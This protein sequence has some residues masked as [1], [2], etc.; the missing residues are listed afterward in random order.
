ML[1]TGDFKVVN[2]YTIVGTFIRKAWYKRMQEWY[3]VNTV[4]TLSNEELMVQ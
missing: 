3:K 4:L 2:S 1:I